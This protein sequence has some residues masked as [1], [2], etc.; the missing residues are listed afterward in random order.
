MLFGKRAE[1]AAGDEGLDQA[2]E[3]V[4]EGEEG[5]GWEG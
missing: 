5:E 4:G 3:D 1:A 2:V